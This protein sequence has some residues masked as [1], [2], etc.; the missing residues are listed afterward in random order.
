VYFDFHGKYKTNVVC[1]ENGESLD[2]NLHQG[3]NR[4][5]KLLKIILNR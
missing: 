5:L 1:A 3:F 2:N 4:Y